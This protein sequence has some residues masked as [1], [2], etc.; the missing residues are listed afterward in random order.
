MPALAKVI[1][2]PGPGQFSN[3]IKDASFTIDST[4]AAVDG[5]GNSYI[6]VTHP[7]VV[8]GTKNGLYFTSQAD[9]GGLIP[10]GRKRI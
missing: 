9:V 10:L 2:E 5:S 4:N 3:L 1:E 7:Q 8:G 6:I